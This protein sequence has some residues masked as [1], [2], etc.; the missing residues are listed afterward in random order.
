M[1]CEDLFN[2]FGHIVLALRTDAVSVSLA[3]ELA[4][5]LGVE[6]G[7]WDNGTRSNH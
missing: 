1:D 4:R 3:E 5:R 7:L 2:G 6:L